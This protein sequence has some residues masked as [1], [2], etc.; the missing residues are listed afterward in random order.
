MHR[1]RKLDERSL[2]NGVSTIIPGDS[3]FMP[4][5]ADFLTHLAPRERRVEAAPSA[6]MNG[7]E[8]QVWW[9]RNHTRS[10]GSIAQLEEDIFTPL[11]AG[12]ESVAKSL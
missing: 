6:S 2:M 3:A 1:T 7:C 4:V 12:I 5:L 8:A 10:E 11:Q 9:R